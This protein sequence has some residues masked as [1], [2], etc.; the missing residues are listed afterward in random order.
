MV[1]PQGS[2]PCT[3]D[4]REAE[5]APCLKQA[6]VLPS[7]LADLASV[8]LLPGGFCPFFLSFLLWL[9]MRARA[10]RTRYLFLPCPLRGPH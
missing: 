10:F 5:E 7:G 6:P 2:S 4:L 8:C 9:H 1:E 3:W